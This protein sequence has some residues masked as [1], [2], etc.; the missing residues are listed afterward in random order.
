MSLSIRPYR[1][2]DF[3]TLHKLDQVCFPPGI[4]YSKFMLHYFLD[5][6]E[7]TCL[8]A[9]EGDQTVGFL[10]AESSP[11]DAHIITVDVDP[12]ARR[13]GA[14]SWLLKKI[15]N[16]FARQSIES[17][18]IETAVDN[19]PAIAFWQH[20]GYRTEAVIKRY[21]LGRIDAY[22]MRKRLPAEPGESG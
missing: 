4:S 22:E 2:A 7:S 15:E 6:P 21:Y 16:E 14:G 12:S 19:A 18:L 8:V 17:V 13:T 9:E 5:L 3:R 11:P 20:H 1:P 10:L